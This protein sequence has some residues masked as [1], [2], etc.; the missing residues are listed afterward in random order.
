MCDERVVFGLR[1]TAVDPHYFQL[2]ASLCNCGNSSEEL[3][4]NAHQ[5]GN[6]SKA[7]YYPGDRYNYYAVTLDPWDAALESD[8]HPL[9]KVWKKA[10]ISEI[11]KLVQSSEIAEELKP[12]ITF[13]EIVKTE[14]GFISGGT[15]H[16]FVEVLC[17]YS[18]CCDC[19][20]IICQV[21]MR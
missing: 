2:N 21:T 8:R 14:G 16:V 18:I 9:F 19:H 10:L 11:P 15:F 3:K 17:N 12:E 6:S 4:H 20:V 13:L 1:W 5:P 7:N